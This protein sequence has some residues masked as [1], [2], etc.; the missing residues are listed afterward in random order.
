M[1]EDRLLRVLRSL[2]T[3]LGYLRQTLSATGRHGE[4]LATMAD[5]VMH[6]ADMVA[7]LMRGATGAPE[8]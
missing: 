5:Q 3:D 2:S 1:D 6:E 8:N 7:E 4:N